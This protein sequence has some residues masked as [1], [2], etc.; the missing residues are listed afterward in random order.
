MRRIPYQ[1]NYH[2]TPRSDPYGL[3]PIEINVFK[4]KGKKPFQG[5]KRQGGKKAFNCYSCGKPG[6][7]AKDCRLKNIVYRPQLNMLRR[8][9]PKKN[10]PP[11][12]ATTKNT[13]ED[14]I[15]NESIK[16]IAQKIDK[17]LDSFRVNNDVKDQKEDPDYSSVKET[18]SDWEQLSKEEQKRE[19]RQPT[20]KSGASKQKEQK[21]LTEFNELTYRRQKQNT[22][23]LDYRCVHQTACL[24]EYCK[25]HYNNKGERVYILRYR[26][27]ALHQKQCKDN[28]Y[29]EHLG[30]KRHEIFFPG[31]P[32][33]RL[34][35]I[36]IELKQDKDTEECYIVDWYTCMHDKCQK[37][38]HQKKLTGFLLESE[39]E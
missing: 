3:K 36:R 35:T 10:G 17:C 33:R 34:E 31:S 2:K 22:M 21:L 14:Y 12:L 27:K 18:D 39:K 23:H 32:K 16:E 11:R 20:T 37:H 13:Q 6:H 24:K 4:K 30:S 26:C 15:V 19:L 8:T 29:D 25:Y 1:G 7:I 5:K 9:L 38:I 28:T